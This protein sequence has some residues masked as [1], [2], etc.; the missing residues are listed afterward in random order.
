MNK[1][2]SNADFRTLFTAYLPASGGKEATLDLTID[3][4]D[5][6]YVQDSPVLDLCTGL[7]VAPA[8]EPRGTQVAFTPAA[9]G[10]AAA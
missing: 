7:C 4:L 1:I 8:P 9:L 3:A 6:W 10:Y 5:G 2:S